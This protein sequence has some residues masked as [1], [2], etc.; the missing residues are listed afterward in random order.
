MYMLF[1]FQKVGLLCGFF[2]L[3]L[4]HANPAFTENNNPNNSF[5]NTSFIALL[6]VLR[7]FTLFQCSLHQS[8][9][10]SKAVLPAKGIASSRYWTPLHMEENCGLQSAATGIDKKV[11]T[12]SV[13]AYHLPAF[14]SRSHWS[15]SVSGM[16]MVQ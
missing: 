16:A 7:S 8:M 11:L 9:G 10:N 14:D 12:T 5:Q 1:Y 13:M 6:Q 4:F 15:S 2:G 3:A